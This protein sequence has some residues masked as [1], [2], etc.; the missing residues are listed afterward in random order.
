MCRTV[1]GE[2]EIACGSEHYRQGKYCYY[3][4]DIEEDTLCQK[5]D[6]AGS[7]AECRA[8][9]D[10]EHGECHDR[11]QEALERVAA[12][13]GSGCRAPYAFGCE[14]G[15]E[16]M[17]GGDEC[18]TYRIVVDSEKRVKTLFGQEGE[19]ERRVRMTGGEPGR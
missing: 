12:Q 11:Q 13:I 19:G 10:L 17:G 7:C 6:E 9:T 18:G 4:R 14:A 5:C 1:A 16:C 2:C 15:S 3:C 8:G